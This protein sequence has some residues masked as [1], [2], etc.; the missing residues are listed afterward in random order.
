MSV[1]ELITEGQERSD[2]RDSYVAVVHRRRAGRRHP[3]MG[4]RLLPGEHAA[5]L[6][7]IDTVYDEEDFGDAFKFVDG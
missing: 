4:E 3:P 7:V 2:Q 1:M 5:F 6:A